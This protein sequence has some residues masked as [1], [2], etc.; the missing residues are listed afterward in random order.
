MPAIIYVIAPGFHDDALR[1]DLAVELSRVTFPYLL[2]ISLAALMG[3]V[4]NA[5]DKFA[6]FAA[7]PILV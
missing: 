3:G 5:H 6:P 4:L 1:Y 2:L 7:A